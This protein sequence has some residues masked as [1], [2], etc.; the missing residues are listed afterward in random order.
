MFSAEEL[1]SEIRSRIPSNLGS[2]GWYIIT[3][4][5]LT[6][7]TTLRLLIK[8]FTQASSLVA[9]GKPEE[10]SSLYV[11]ATG[12]DSPLTTAEKQQLSRRLQDVL[13]KAWTLVGIPLVVLAAA[14]LAKVEGRDK[15]DFDENAARTW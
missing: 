11:Y 12:S 4:C 9:C 6:S 7:P 8:L 15:I 3:V 13:A 5:T 10:L 1:Y 2:H 14:A